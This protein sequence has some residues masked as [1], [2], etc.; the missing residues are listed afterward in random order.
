[1][2]FVEAYQGLNTCTA[3]SKANLALPPAALRVSPFQGGA[4]VLR[5]RRA[6]GSHRGS[7]RPAAVVP[8]ASITY[9][10]PNTGVE[11]PL[12]QQFWLGE[13]TR[14]MGAASKSKKIA[15]ISVKVYAVSLYVEAEK[16]AKE[17]GVRDRGGFFDNDDDFCQALVDGG[18][19][20]IL[21][22]QL[23]RKVDGQMFADALAETLEPR[24][25]LTGELA[26]LEKFKAFFQD[27]DLDKGTNVLLM[28]RTDA[29]LD[30]VLRQG[31]GHDYSKVV[32]ELSIP[33]ASLCRALYE[34]YLG[35]TTVIPEAK[36][37]WA[38][39][40]RALLESEK[41]HGSFHEFLSGL[42]GANW[43]DYVPAAWASPGFSWDKLGSFS[44]ES[45]L[46]A[47]LEVVETRNATVPQ[48]LQ[49]LQPSI[50]ERT[51]PFCTPERY[52]P[53]QA[54]YASC[55]GPTVTLAYVPKVCSLD[56]TTHQVVCDPAKIVLTKA[57]GGCTH[58]YATAS[59]WT[60]KECKIAG[61]VGFTKEAAF[62][63]GSFK[64]PAIQNLT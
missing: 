2:V 59:S 54:A 16:A 60:G 23:V 53:S 61:T 43:T 29:T 14:C 26:T 9:K 5:V 18:F 7:C 41:A 10:E 6:A 34:V 40:A 33:S 46:Q 3:V 52:L 12:V 20:K 63:G 57:P 51:A 49:E 45:N 27:K 17:L 15:F 50:E 55:S 28:Y 22:I 36:K 4:N 42:L 44:Y 38:K 11:F 25:R 48:N 64:L 13:P 62:G 47:F 1:M 32:A 30:V 19:I 56:E 31:D 21:Q 24:M 8:Q 39:G 37:E 35:S 58:K